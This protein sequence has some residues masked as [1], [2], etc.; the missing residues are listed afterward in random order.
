MEDFVP[1]ELALKLKDKGFRKP[2]IATYDKD[3][4]LGY[5]YVQPT[6]I[7]A[8][9]FNECLVYGNDCVVAPTIS[10]VLKWMREEKGI[11]ICIIYSIVPFVN[12]EY[13]IV[14]I[15]GVIYA[16]ADD[17]YDTYEEATLAGIEYTINN[18][19]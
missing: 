4:M 18:L 2:C 14:E 15:D 10:Q 8:V 19:I 5:N 6:S 3:G 16:N 13:E 17:G 1:Y 9:G 7:C 12:W 11:H